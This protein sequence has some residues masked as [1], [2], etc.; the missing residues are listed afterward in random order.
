VDLDVIVKTIGA[1]LPPGGKAFTIEIDRI[2]SPENA[3]EH[4]IVFLADP[5]F[6][7]PVIESMA[8]VV[9]VKKGE[10]IADKICLEVS[11]PYCAFAKIGQLFEDR[12]PIF[13]GPIHATANVHPSA[14]VHESATVGPFS[15]IGKD[16]SIGQGTVI[17]AL[18]VIEN[19]AR[20]GNNCRIDSGAVIRREC[21]IGNRVIIQSNA[22]IGSEGFGNAKEGD[23]WVRIPSFG[24]VVIGDDAEVGANTT[25][26]RGALGPTVIGNGVKI[27]NLV[28]VA[29]NVSVGDNT[30][31]AAQAGIAGSM[32]IGKRVMI[33]GQAG[34]AGQF[35]VEDDAFIGAQAGVSKAVE[36]GARVTGYPARDLMTMR[37]I[38]AA[39]QRLP[40]LVKEVKRLRRE[41]EELK[42]REIGGDPRRKAG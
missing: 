40:E 4:S 35:E 33:G 37:R 10:A 3:D 25:I 31:V 41:I 36:K 29:H 19:R 22:V 42:N 34:F 26:D 27:D 8:R 7:G 9:I 20:I 18:C 38:E 30:A 14:S 11:D 21:A 39:Q 23:R 1:L 13:D 15:V 12:R 2:S 28:Q 5:K 6:R 32:K 17:G 24:N 16:C